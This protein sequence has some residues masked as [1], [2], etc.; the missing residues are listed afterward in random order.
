MKR[1]AV[2]GATAVVVV[3]LAACGQ[4]GTTSGS[5]PATATPTSSAVAAPAPGGPTLTIAGMGYSDQLTVSPGAQIT[6]VNNDEVEHTVT[7]RTNGLF[8]VEIGGKQQAV[9]TAPSQPGEYAFHCRY[10]PGM[11]STLIV[12]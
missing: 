9:F 6:I 7:S 5:G 8:D 12:K 10:H 4:S 1:I 2:Y 3:G 11:V